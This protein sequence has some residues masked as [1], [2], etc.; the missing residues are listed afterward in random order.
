M[1]KHFSHILSKRRSFTLIEML[2]VIA[3]I[4]ILASLLMPALRNGLSAARQ[5]SCANNLHGIGTAMVGYENDYR[6]YCPALQESNI[7][8]NYWCYKLLPYLGVDTSTANTPAER[9][10]LRQSPPLWCPEKK[11]KADINSGTTDWYDVICYAESSF[12]Y[13][14]LW[15]NLT[16]TKLFLYGG[17]SGA[18]YSVNSASNSSHPVVRGTS[19]IVFVAEMGHKISDP[20][21]YTHFSMVNSNFFEGTPVGYTPGFRHLNNKNTLMLDLSVKSIPPNIVKTALLLP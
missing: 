16:N 10:L 13:M 9:R 8:E 7:P 2:V 1:H 20:R 19:N 5:V 12:Y 15:Y 21:G 11:E 18:I 17:D 14:R 3:I 6:V 4:A